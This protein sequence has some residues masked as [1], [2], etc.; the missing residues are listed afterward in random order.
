MPTR[1]IQ[2]AEIGA[3]IIVTNAAQSEL[4]GTRAVVDGINKRTRRLHIKLDETVGSRGSAF[5]SAHELMKYEPNQR[6]PGGFF[7]GQDIYH[8]GIRG[9]F[10][11]FSLPVYGAT[12]VIVGSDPG[13]DGYL[14]VSFH[15]ASLS[16]VQVDSLSSTLPPPLP[17]GFRAGQIVGYVQDGM[18][19]FQA[20][21]CT[22]RSGTPV[23]VARRAAAPDQIAVCVRGRPEGALV[24]IP[25][26]TLV[27]VTIE[28]YG[29][30]TPVFTRAIALELVS[31][32]ALSSTY[33]S[34]KSI[35]PAPAA[36]FRKA[37]ELLPP[38]TPVRIEGLSKVEL[39]GC[40]GRV[41]SGASD[42]RVPVS[43]TAADGSLTS[44]RVKPHNLRHTMCWMMLPHELV[45]LCVLAVLDGVAL[46]RLERTCTR[47]HRMLAQ[48]HCWRACA[49]Y[50]LGALL[51]HMSD[52]S[53]D[54]CR[55]VIISHHRV[56]RGQY[57]YDD[58]ANF[59]PVKI[60]ESADDWEERYYMATPELAASANYL[61]IGC[62]E[63]HVGFGFPGDADSA[64]VV[65]VRDAATLVPRG[66]LRAC[67]HKMVICGDQIVYSLEGQPHVW[68][69]D[70]NAIVTS[71]D[72][73]SAPRQVTMGDEVT[74][75][76]GQGHLLLV[77]FKNIGVELYD[78]SDAVVVTSVYCLTD[79]DGGDIF[80][81]ICSVCF[82]PGD[83]ALP[84]N[85]GVTD[86]GLLIVLYPSCPMEMEV[87]LHTFEAGLMAV[88]QPSGSMQD[89][90]QKCLGSITAVEPAW[91]EHRSASRSGR[92]DR[93]VISNQSFVIATEADL[94][95]VWRWEDEHGAFAIDPAPTH[96]LRE[97]LYLDE[98][99][100]REKHATPTWTSA[101][102]EL[103]P[104]LEIALNDLFLFTS[105]RAG[106]ALCVWSLVEGALLYRLEHPFDRN[107]TGMY[108]HDVLP[109]GCAATSLVLLN[110]GT[111]AVMAGSGGHFFTWD[112][113][114]QMSGAHGFVKYTDGNEH[115]RPPDLVKAHTWADTPHTWGATK[116]PYDR[117]GCI[118]GQ[119]QTPMSAPSVTLLST[120]IP[121][122][123]EVTPA[124]AVVP[125]S[126]AP[127][128]NDAGPSQ[129][130]AAAPADDRGG[131]PAGELVAAPAPSEETLQASAEEEVRRQAKRQKERAKK[132]AQKHRKTWRARL[133][134][135]AAAC[136]S[137]L[138]ADDIDAVGASADEMEALAAHLPA[139]ETE[140]HLRV[141]RH[142][143]A[144]R[145]QQS[146]REAAL[147][148]E[149]VGKAAAVLQAAWRTR[150]ERRCTAGAARACQ[151]E[152]RATLGA[153]V[154]IQAAERAV[155]ARRVF[156]VTRAHPRSI[157]YYELDEATDSFVS[158]N[159]VGEGSFGVVYRASKLPSL[160]IVRG[161]KAVKRT[162]QSTPDEREALWK[163]YAARHS[164]ARDPS[165]AL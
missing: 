1:I 147:E 34:T 44:V 58:F 65:I 159:V 152:L 30:Y 140:E 120:F 164:S 158:E 109:D 10:G 20:D 85:L 4:N 161:P 105:S 2:L 103:G 117:A 93:K 97:P 8:T 165:P 145:R 119:K 29:D 132:D 7:A 19:A 148:Q 162:R 133:A 69:Q 116:S 115:R 91:A 144:R 90:R 142:W 123:T 104:R 66:E 18:N 94:I 31:L 21:D 83:S 45:A 28:A 124:N 22:L 73:Q 3:H 46:A 52:A 96:L 143:I 99:Q 17:G 39:N 35:V 57:V 156:A 60:D 5:I 36:C 87:S 121:P 155:A 101:L 13:D 149:Q 122:V 59:P 56:Q 146:E 112:F 102:E 38:H 76:A 95:S 43:V 49:V 61:V 64:P 134:E 127:P 118:P 111:K 68:I 67:I 86:E 40:C 80:P 70:I 27:E 77:G 100:R 33:A 135:A 42:G 15:N 108:V 153:A 32:D 26:S 63:C 138:E 160:A 139:G 98:R 74:C 54:E 41:L 53:R 37:V 24:C 130:V 131:S 114:D 25:I 9:F 47:L 78:V 62:D 72:N 71:T 125:A 151:A 107:A 50:G 79:F 141:A 6:L 128:T 88:T 126:F 11:Q 154:R 55:R 48:P 113:S 12:G 82:G 89:W 137:A 163:E 14:V 23:E 136:Q 129:P 150:N 157:D 106:T 92:L 16:A 84:V 81:N 75:L 110:G 51:L